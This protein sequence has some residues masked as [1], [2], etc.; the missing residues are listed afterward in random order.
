V[1]GCPH[2][3]FA[4]FRRLAGLIEA[5]R[6]NTRHPDVRFLVV[7]GTCSRALLQRTHLPESLAAFGVE[8][9][10]DTCV[11]HSPIVGP[12]AKVIMTDSGKCAYYAPG[13]LGVRVAFGN[14]ADCVRSAVAGRVCRRKSTWDEC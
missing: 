2:F 7:T 11:F 3:S 8:I 14:L 12:D 10:L 5:E 6:P 9:T 13:E 4:E 1:L